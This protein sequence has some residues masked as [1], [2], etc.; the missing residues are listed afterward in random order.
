MLVLLLLLLLLLR[1]GGHDGGGHEG[2]RRGWRCRAIAV[3]PGRAPISKQR[4]R[5]RLLHLFVC[6]WC[7]WHLSSSCQQRRGQGWRGWRVVVVAAV[8]F[9]PRSQLHVVAWQKVRRHLRRES[10]HEILNLVVLMVVVVKMMV[11]V[12]MVVVVLMVMLMLMMLM[13]VQQRKCL[14]MKSLV[15]NRKK[16]GVKTRNTPKRD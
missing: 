7:W 4:S 6:R 8:A 11:V 14:R 3:K 9:L 15:G 13:M 5:R 12:V 1:G 16:R 2:K 10:C